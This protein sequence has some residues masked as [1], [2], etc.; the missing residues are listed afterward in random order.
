MLF[1]INCCFTGIYDWTQY[2]KVLCQLHEEY[3]PIVREDLGPY[4]TV[5]HVFDPDDAR[6]VYAAEGRSP[7]IRPLQE[8][9]KLY[10]QKKDKSPGLGNT[11][12]TLLCIYVSKT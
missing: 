1:F 12:V 4:Y 7:V 11:W 9:I 5:I 2:H 6:T 8:T 10:R 3:G